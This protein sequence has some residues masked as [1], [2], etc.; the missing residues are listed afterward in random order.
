[1]PEVQ[2]KYYCDAGGSAPVNDWLEKLKREDRIGFARCV[3]KIRVLAEMGLDAR[4]PTVEYLRDGI[5]ELRAKHV[6]IH[7]RILFFYQ[8][9]EV[10]I[11]AHNLVKKSNKVPESDISVA[12]ERKRQFKSNPKRHTYEQKD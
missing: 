12:V 4:R 8:N 9:D 3:A 7:Y 11:L 10:V 5:F 2:I 1:M 6:H